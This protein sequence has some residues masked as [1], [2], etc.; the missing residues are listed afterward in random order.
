MHVLQ[1]DVFQ[2]CGTS[3]C[4]MLVAALHF[5]IN[6]QNCKHETHGS[7]AA[8]ETWLHV[9]ALCF[10]VRRVLGVVNGARALSKS[11]VEKIVPASARLRQKRASVRQGNRHVLH[12]ALDFFA[13]LP[14][15]QPLLEASTA[16]VDILV[17]LLVHDDRAVKAGFRSADA[18][19]AQKVTFSCCGKR[20]TRT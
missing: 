19:P 15:T 3:S 16:G 4:N 9:G 6:I 20:E 14:A 5:T 18:V 2:T 11:L 12:C 13:R 7:T 17:Q 1:N 8:S 10:T